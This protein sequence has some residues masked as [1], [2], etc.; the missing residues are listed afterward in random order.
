MSNAR[1]MSLKTRFVVRDNTLLIDLGTRRPI[2]SSAP[3]SGGFVR[4]RYI[5]NHQVPANPAVLARDSHAVWR[6]PS[7]ALGIIATRMGAAGP[8]VGLMTAVPLKQLVVIREEAPTIWVEGFVTVG[9]SNAVRAGEP[10]ESQQPKRYRHAPDT[11]NIILVTNARLST[12]AMVGAVQVVTESKTATLISECVQSLTGQ[13]SVTGTGT[14]AV[15]VAGGEGPALR[16]SGTHTKI[17]EMIGRL[18][19]RGITEGLARCKQWQRCR[20]I[21]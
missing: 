19:H 12:S 17:G 18:V 16:Y 8:C 21:E 2:L 6:D 5:L 20:V 7:R 1:H 3:R 14:D 11:I 4:A 15:V 13:D 10:I 9:I